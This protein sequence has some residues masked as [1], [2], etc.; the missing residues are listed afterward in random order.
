MLLACPQPVSVWPVSHLSASCLAYLSP[1]LPIGLCQVFVCCLFCLLAC[2]SVR[3]STYSLP[4]ACLPT[5]YPCF[6]ATNGKGAPVLLLRW[7]LQL[8]PDAVFF[9]TL[10]AHFC[11]LR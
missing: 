4:Y 5:A 7:D 10:L 3:L 6:V 1:L 9:V 2:L 11:D 8:S